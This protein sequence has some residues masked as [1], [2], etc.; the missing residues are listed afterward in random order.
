MQ[1]MWGSDLAPPGKPGPLVPVSV[2]RNDDTIDDCMRLLRVRD[3][4]GRTH[5][6]VPSAACWLRRVRG[7]SAMQLSDPH[8]FPMRGVVPPVVPVQLALLDDQLWHARAQQ[9]PVGDG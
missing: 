2:Y 7:S 4:M 3:C 8:V 6:G 1:P 5:V 9:Q